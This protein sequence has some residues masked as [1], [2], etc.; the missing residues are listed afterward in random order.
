MGRGNV[1]SG[2][3]AFIMESARLV[4]G[5]VG[6]VCR[7]RTRLSNLR[8]RD[9]AGSGMVRAG[10]DHDFHILVESREKAHE[11]LNGKSVEA[12]V[13]ECRN[14]GLGNAEESRRFS[15]LEFPIFDAFVKNEGQAGFRPAL[16][17]V[18]KSEIGK[19]I[20]RAFGDARVIHVTF[21]SGW[22]I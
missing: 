17:C 22:S 3:P 19:N 2:K 9:T 6:W 15:L 5:S 16:L 13:L 7:K 20:G 11:P 8:N 21:P 12:V 4:K 10:A 1:F 18:G 14:L